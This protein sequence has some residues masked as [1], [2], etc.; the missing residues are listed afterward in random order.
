MGACVLYQLTTPF[1]LQMAFSDQIPPNKSAV[2]G[3]KTNAMDVLGINK[4]QFGRK[5]EN[6]KITPTITHEQA[7]V[8]KRTLEYGKADEESNHQ[9]IIHQHGTSNTLSST[10]DYA[11][12]NYM[13]TIHFHA[14]MNYITPICI[15]PFS[16]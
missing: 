7:M 15:Y 11:N 6:L 13:K 10:V 5:T 4:T 2:S 16:F 9:P 1:L 12:I 8:N 14:T 3:T